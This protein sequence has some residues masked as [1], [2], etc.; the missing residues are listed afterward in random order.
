MPQRSWE[1]TETLW[2]LACGVGNVWSPMSQKQESAKRETANERTGFCKNLQLLVVSC[3]DLCFSETSSNIWRTARILRSLET[4]RDSRPP[5]CSFL[6]TIELWAI[7]LLSRRTFLLAGHT[8]VFQTWGARQPQLTSK[9]TVSEGAPQRARN[10]PRIETALQPLSLSGR[11]LAR[12]VPQIYLCHTPEGEMHS[13]QI[14]C[15]FRFCIDIHWERWSFTIVLVC[16][17]LFP[18]AHVIDD[19]LRNWLSHSLS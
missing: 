8:H 9:R 14:A 1:V 17:P 4:L 19:S 6:S 3:E 18:D 12:M 10:L 16:E 2:R 13:P 15:R 7:N 5:C 11:R